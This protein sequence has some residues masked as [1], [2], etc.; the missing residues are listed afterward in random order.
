MERTR[1]ERVKG[2]KAVRSIL[3]LIDIL[4]F[5]QGLH[6]IVQ[7]DGL[8][9]TSSDDDDDDDLEDDKDDDDDKD[10]ENEE[11]E[12]KEEEVGILKTVIIT[13]I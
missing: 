6:N 12:E 9:D 13:S 8:G 1:C 10:E 4:C 2:F 7:L 11:E 3:Y 5:L